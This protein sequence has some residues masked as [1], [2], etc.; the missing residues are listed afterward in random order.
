MRIWLERCVLCISA[1]ALMSCAARESE[2]VVRPPSTIVAVSRCADCSVNRDFRGRIEVGS[3]N[4][5]SD[6]GVIES[7]LKN[8]V[9]R[10][11]LRRSLD[12]YGLLMKKRPRNTGA[13]Y[14]I[15]AQLIDFHRYR[16]AIYSARPIIRYVLKDTRTG[17]YVLNLLVK[18]SSKVKNGPHISFEPALRTVIERA[19][20][21]NIAEFLSR[22]VGHKISRSAYA[23]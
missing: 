4:M 13:A 3:T 5:K 21:A 8:D 19:V 18:T 17:E 11:A 12:N 6:D 10:S 23:S 14:V 9:F 7:L 20:K 1:L 22:L 16:G 2:L 15:E